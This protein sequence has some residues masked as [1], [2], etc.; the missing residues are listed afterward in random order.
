M[1][2]TSNKFGAWLR[3][4][5]PVNLALL[6]SEIRHQFEKWI[7]RFNAQWVLVRVGKRIKNLEADGARTRRTSFYELSQNYEVVAMFFEYRGQFEKAD[8]V[9]M[10]HG[11]HPMLPADMHEGVY[12]RAGLRAVR[13]QRIDTAAKYLELAKAVHVPQGEQPFF[14]ILESALRRATI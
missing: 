9:T 7:V 11:K 1:K 6:R 14:E 8:L 13:Q 12:V 4:V 2:K 5:L 3:V 10:T